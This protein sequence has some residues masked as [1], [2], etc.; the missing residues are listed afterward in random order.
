MLTAHNSALSASNSAFGSEACIF[1]NSKGIPMKQFIIFLG[2]SSGLVFAQV[3]VLVDAQWLKENHSNSKLVV[4]QVNQ[5][6]LDFEREHI[7]GSRF[8]WPGWLAPDSP[9]GNLNPPDAKTATRVLQNLG[10]NT[11]SHIVLSY[12]RNELPAAARMFVTLEH[13]GLEGKVSLLN[14]GLEAWKKQGYSISTGPSPNAQKGNFKAN[15]GQMLVDRFYV[16][17]KLKEKD[18]VIVDARMKRFYDGEP[19]GHPRDGHIP[20]AANIPYT[21][22]IDNETSGLKQSDILHQFF[23][24]VIPAKD[25]EAVTY[26]NSGQ[27]ASVVYLAGRALGY[28]LKVYDGSMQEWSRTEGCELEKTP[29]D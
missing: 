9:E 16:Q 2:L 13:L 10:V 8:L 29:K 15:P 14:G 19:S 28:K 20:G 23:Q 5:L 26:C 3:P 24:P 21:D 1:V 7:P 27:T 22:L 18:A 25:K 4:L 12:I 11:D 6:R 17:K